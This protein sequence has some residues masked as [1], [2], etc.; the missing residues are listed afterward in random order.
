MH[1]QLGMLSINFAS[2]TVVGVV[3]L[4][5]VFAVIVAEVMTVGDVVIPRGSRLKL[6]YDDTW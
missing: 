3:V 1:R 4:M 6:G 2:S 5:V